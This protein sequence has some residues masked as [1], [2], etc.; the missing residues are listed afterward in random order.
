[1]TALKRYYAVLL[2]FAPAVVAAAEYPAPVEGDWIA[3]DFHFASGETMPELRLHYY[4][5]GVPRGD[6]AVLIMHGTTGSGRGFLTDTFAGHL[7][8]PG[9][10]LDAAK[11][12]I[13]LTEGLHLDH[14]RLVMG[15]SMGAMLT[16]MWGETYPDFMDALMPLASAPVEI[17]GRNRMLRKMMIDA[18]ENDPDWEGGNYTKPPIHGL[19]CAMDILTIMTTSPLQLQ[20]QYPTREAADA[21]LA[22]TIHDRAERQDAN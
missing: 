13:V 14:L 21:G 12:F 8:A 5:L 19:E 11:Y 2:L 9:Q 22:K 7:F 18:I 20:K 16:W 6:N 4:T 17:A 3:H 15:T 10:L 1:M